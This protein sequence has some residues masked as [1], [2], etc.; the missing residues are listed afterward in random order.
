M[1]RDFPHRNQVGFAGARRK[2]VPYAG[3]IELRCRDRV[4]FASAPVPR[5]ESSR[6]KAR[7]IGR[8]NP[9]NPDGP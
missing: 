8:Y 1:A 7:R 6:W 2:L 9:P 5:W 3:P 4:G